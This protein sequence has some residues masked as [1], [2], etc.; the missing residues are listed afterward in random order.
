MPSNSTQLLGLFLWRAGLLFV[1]AWS[2]YKT[3]SRVLEVF[4][5]ADQA[6]VGISLILTGGTM[7]ILSLVLERIHAARLEGD[8]LQ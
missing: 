7:V 5:V 6:V 2:F 3:T 4:E 1:G 8:L